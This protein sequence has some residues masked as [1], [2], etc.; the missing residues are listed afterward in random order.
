MTSDRVTIGSGRGMYMGQDQEEQT[1]RQEGRDQDRGIRTREAGVETIE[2]RGGKIHE[3][4]T[5]G[6]KEPASGRESLRSDVVRAGE[7]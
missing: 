1:R 6:E 3:P 5:F 4:L 7:S 2:T